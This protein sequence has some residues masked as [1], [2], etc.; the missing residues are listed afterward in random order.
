M[1]KFRAGKGSGSG[2]A[3][4]DDRHRAASAGERPLALG[5]RLGLERRMKT[6]LVIRHAPHEG[7]AGYREPIEAAGYAI[8][9]VDVDEPRFASL[10]FAAPDLLVLLGGPMGVYEQDKH[11]WIAGELARIAQRLERRQPTLGICFGS[12]LVAAAL[13]ADVYAGP[14]K[15]VGFDALALTETPAAAPLRHLEGVPVLHWHGDTFE[16][17]QGAELLASTE[18]YPH[19]AFSVGREILALQFHAEM[20]LDDRF[21]V[22]TAKAPRYVQAAGTTVERLTA[23]HE[24]YGAQVVAA[25]RAMLADWLRALG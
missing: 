19:Q 6:A 3:M 1:K 23:D 14:V 20:G 21:H 17:P 12:Q 24:R 25:G 9:T 10:D 13:G 4:V 15:E 16:L 5:F 22:W 11:P 8:D 2:A 7:L 18:R